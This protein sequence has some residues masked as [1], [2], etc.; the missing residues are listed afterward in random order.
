[1]SGLRKARIAGDSMIRI[2]KLRFGYNSGASVLHLDEFVVEAAEDVLVVGPSGCGK[3]TLLHLIA[4]LLLPTSGRIEVD[5]QN[6]AA[7]PGPARDRFR[8]QHIGIVLQQFHLLPT[9][10]ALQ[11]LLVAQTIAGLPID[12][13]GAQAILAALGVADRADAFPH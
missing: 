12:R 7:L 6:L 8:G 10:T 11:N 9:L 3:T 5:G 13:P 1:L 2:E 4:R